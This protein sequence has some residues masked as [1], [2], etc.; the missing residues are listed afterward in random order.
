MNNLFFEYNQDTLKPSSYPELTRLINV[1]YKYPSMVIEIS[2]HTDAQ[3]NEAKNRILSKVRANSVSGYLRSKG[4]AAT[5]LQAKG[6]GQTKPLA[7]NHSAEGRARNRRVEFI[8]L[9][10]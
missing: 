3:G 9:K 10:K 2:G 6:Y 7:S 5:R 4:I 1:L 8:I